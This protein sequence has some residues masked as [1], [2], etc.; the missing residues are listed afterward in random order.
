MLLY[1]MGFGSLAVVALFLLVLTAVWM[2]AQFVWTFTHWDLADFDLMAY[3]HLAYLVV[4]TT[5]AVG[6]GAAFWC[7]SGAAWRKPTSVR[8]ST[9]RRR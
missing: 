6:T 1:S 3:K 2:Y 9:P 8:S 5:F 4:G 7:L